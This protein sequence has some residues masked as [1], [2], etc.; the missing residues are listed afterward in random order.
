MSYGRFMSYKVVGGVA[1]VLIC[2]LAGYRSAISFVQKN[3]SAVVLAIIVLSLRGG[4][5]DPPGPQARPPA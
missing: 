1:W 2:T 3:F 4:L 5:G